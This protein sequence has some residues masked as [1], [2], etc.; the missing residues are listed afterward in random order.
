MFSTTATLEIMV[1]ALGGIRPSV[2]K[3]LKEK[4]IS[5]VLC[6]LGKGNGTT[7]CVPWK[8]ANVGSDLSLAAT[9]KHR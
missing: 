8:A 7:D 2:A 4:G 3:V 5:G 1:S 9:A 6:V